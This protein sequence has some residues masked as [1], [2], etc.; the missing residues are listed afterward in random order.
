MNRSR[1]ARMRLTRR[2]R[3]SPL[4][5][6]ESIRAREA[7][8]KAVSAPA[9]KAESSSDIT[10]MLAA[11][12]RSVCVSIRR[13]SH[14]AMPHRHCAGCGKPPHIPTQE[15]IDAAGVGIGGDAVHGAHHPQLKLQASSTGRRSGHAPRSSSVRKAF[16]SARS[17]PGAMKLWPIPRARMKVSAPSRTFLSWAM[18]SRMASTPPHPPGTA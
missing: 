16:T 10:T 15:R 14:Q 2:A 1:E 5:S 17:M 11:S 8:V 7:A 4:F 3:R 13:S 6:S 12:Q 18:A 9:K